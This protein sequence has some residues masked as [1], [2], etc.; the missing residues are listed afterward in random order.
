M[1]DWSEEIFPEGVGVKL[2]KWAKGEGRG[3][4]GKIPHPT[5]PLYQSSELQAINWTKFQ[6]FPKQPKSNFLRTFR[7]QEK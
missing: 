7:V 2:K 4:E 3:G 6:P 5:S 1:E